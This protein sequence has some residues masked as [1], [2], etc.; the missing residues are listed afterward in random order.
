MAEPGTTSEKCPRCGGVLNA[1]LYGPCA[2]CVS[3]LRADQRQA[4]GE[5]VHDDLFEPAMHV[6]PNA[7]ALKE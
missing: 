3:E 1:D 2:N 7:V 6:T 5:R 4:P